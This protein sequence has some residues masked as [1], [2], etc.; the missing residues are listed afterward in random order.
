MISP[1]VG[2][3]MAR[4]SVTRETTTTDIAPTWLHIVVSDDA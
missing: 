2:Y 4:R 3:R 1:D